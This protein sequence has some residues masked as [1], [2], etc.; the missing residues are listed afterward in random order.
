MSKSVVRNLSYNLILQFVMMVLPLISIPYVS[1]ILGA[2]GI[3]AYS[4]TLSLT[5]YFIIFGTLGTSLY[6]NRQ[7]AYVR[8][9]ADELAKTF[10]AIFVVRAITTTVALGL[11]FFI[12][13]TTDALRTLRLIQSLHIVSAIFDV[14][15]LFIGLEDFKRIVTRNLV[16]RILGLSSIFIFV[17]TPE[18][19]VIYTL[20]NVGISLMSAV[21]M[22]LYVPKAIKKISI[23][24]SSIKLHLW[25]ILR[26][27]VPQIASQIYVLLDKT[28][29]GFL[30]SLTQVGYYTQAD[31][32]IK[33][34]LELITALGV[35][36]LPRMSHI[37]SKGDHSAMDEYLNKHM[38]TVAYVSIPIVFGLAAISN[39]FVPL[40]FG[41][42][43][44]PVILIMMMIAPVLLFIS[45]SSVLG[46]QYLL[47]SNRINEFTISIVAGALINLVLNFLLIPRL[48][49]I[50]AVIGTLMA[51]F[52]VMSIQLYFLH[53]KLEL[54]IIGRNYLNF[55]TA[56]LLMFAVVRFAAVVFPVS[57]YLI[58]VQV[59]IGF[60]VYFIVLLLLRNQTHQQMIVFFGSKLRHFLKV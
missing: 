2:D 27:F 51:E 8:D 7:I 41:P 10:S 29:I 49:A 3:G 6:G 43:F 59:M 38:I 11:Y 56:A 55:A 1:R 23:D 52:T 48:L 34:I 53:G 12:F 44:K 24:I 35:V 4:F 46:V 13:N 37:F 42:N 17:K 30:S 50:G 45:L 15:W 54:K 58:F 9:D 39:E 20:I 28:M 40:F 33:S 21:V 25:P 26:L 36:M 57:I 5:Q 60:A 16:I 22:W 19:V 18:D 32:I 31:R 14:T 47:P